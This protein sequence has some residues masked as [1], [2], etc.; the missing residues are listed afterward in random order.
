MVAIAC[1]SETLNRGTVSSF[2]QERK[3][4]KNV[5]PKTLAWYGDAFK[6]FDGALE[7]E[8]ALKQ[9]IIDLRCRGISP[10]SVNSWL[11]CVNAY[12]DWKQAGYKAQ[13]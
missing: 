7:S 4:L 10:V 11:R 1:E 5:T 3:Y 13:N 12:L 9:R 6:A 2:A 8:I